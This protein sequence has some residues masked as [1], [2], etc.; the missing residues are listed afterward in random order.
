MVGWYVPTFVDEAGDL[1]RLLAAASLGVD[2]VAV[3]IEARNLADVGQRNR[4]LDRPSAGGCAPRSRSWPLGAIVMP[5]VL[6]DIVNP[7]CWPGFPWR[8]LAPSFDVWLPMSYSTERRRDSGWRDGYRYTVE[9][10][11]RLRAAPGST[12]D[13]PVHTISGIA[14]RL[15]RADLEGTV[16]AVRETARWARASTTGVRPVRWRG[17]SS[18]PFAP[19]LSEA[20]VRGLS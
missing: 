20:R 8:E 2:G 13:A 18:R 11:T 1:R 7:G 6:L 10:I 15:I 19:S 16:R 4:R 17:P 5:P 3:D 12:A 14:D 9:N